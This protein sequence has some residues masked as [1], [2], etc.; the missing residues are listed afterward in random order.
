MDEKAVL[1]DFHRVHEIF[2]ESTRRVG[3]LLPILR[4]VYGSHLLNLIAPYT[5]D[6]LANGFGDGGAEMYAH[7][8][9][10]FVE[11]LGQARAHPPGVTGTMAAPLL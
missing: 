8:V 11:F 4:L 5:L 1:R 6:F 3:A 10:R 7:L 2:L 9:G